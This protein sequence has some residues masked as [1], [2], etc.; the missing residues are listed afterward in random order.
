MNRELGGRGNYLGLL[1]SAEWSVGVGGNYADVERLY[2]RC[3]RSLRNSG[4]VAAEAIVL[5]NFGVLY[6]KQGRYEEAEQCYQQSLA[7]RRELM[8]RVGEGTTLVNF[9]LLRE[10]QEDMAGALEFGKQA[11]IALEMAQDAR[12]DDVRELVAMWE[13]KQSEREA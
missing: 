10:A 2:Q 4:S 7:I 8:D 13:A 1:R 9:A 12:R 6:Q 5:N 11:V 3:L